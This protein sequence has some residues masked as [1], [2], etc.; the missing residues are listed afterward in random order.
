MPAIVRRRRRDRYGHRHPKST[1]CVRGDPDRRELGEDRPHAAAEFLAGATRV[2]QCPREILE[3]MCRPSDDDVV[4]GVS[5]QDRR[6]RQ[7]RAG[8]RFHLVGAPL[9]VL[10]R[11]LDVTDRRGDGGI[12]ARGRGGRT[13]SLRRIGQPADPP[14][15]VRPIPAARPT[16]GSMC[17]TGSACECCHA[18][19]VQRRASRR[20]RALG[21]RR[22]WAA[23]DRT[24]VGSESLSVIYTPVPI[25]RFACRPDRSNMATASHLLPRR[26]MRPRRP[27]RSASAEQSRP[28]RAR[29]PRIA[30][31]TA[32]AAECCA[33]TA[34]IGR[35]SRKR[36]R[37][38]RDDRAPVSEARSPA[39][40]SIGW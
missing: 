15:Q 13:D 14:D 29:G 11:R 8:K 31:Q 23:R 32:F 16:G 38:D 24:A 37:D 34:T 6:T 10:E 12:G 7:S 26:W 2:R 22:L 1:A 25:V 39:G 40:G 3:V 19:I 20:Y 35:P 27:V 9:E 21:V 5:E 28:S 30:S 4:P 36:G 17:H 33:T 18:P